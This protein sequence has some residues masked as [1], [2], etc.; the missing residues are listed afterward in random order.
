MPNG[1]AV[2]SDNPVPHLNV[3]GTIRVR[4]IKPDYLSRVVDHGRIIAVHCNTPFSW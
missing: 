2:S 4:W 1:F 3:C